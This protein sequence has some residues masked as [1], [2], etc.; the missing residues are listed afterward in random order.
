MKNK[1]L[2]SI[3]HAHFDKLVSL[4]NNAKKAVFLDKCIFWWQ[5]SKYT[6]D[7][8]KIW[9]TRK[10]PD[11]A[12]ELSI[13]ERS[14]S[15][16]LDEL[17]KSGLLERVCKL[18]ASNK[19]DK[20]QVTK[21]LYIRVTEKLLNILQIQPQD[22]TLSKEKKDS[23]CSFS[24]QFGK[25]D[26]AKLATS[27]YKDK[28]YK[29]TN[30]STVRDDRIVNNLKTPP[31][32]P[33]QV[34]KTAST[35]TY[36]IE[37]QIGERLTERLKNYIK[38]M[39]SNV[40][41]QHDV[42]Y[43]DPNKLFAEV[44]F[45]VTQEMQWSGIENPHHRVN[46]IAKLLRQKQWRTPKGFYNQWDIGNLFREQER[47]RLEKDRPDKQTDVQ[48]TSHLFSD[49]IKP[50]LQENERLKVRMA[51]EYRYSTTNP[52]E[53]NKEQQKLKQSL[54]DII[55]TIGSEESYLKQLE[56]W[57]EQK[58]SSVTR[59]LIDSVAIKIARLY[60]DRQKLMALVEGRVGLAA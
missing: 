54:Q 42:K 7:D 43:S 32:P 50:C 10:L 11:I 29:Q 55:I 1:N 9:F 47:M 5:I 20:F 44:V 23:S 13:S 17:E 45:S 49:R 2:C 22:P 12:H 41:T 3:Y 16:Y 39:L 15:R 31:N 30:N 14:V 40:Q 25:M 46:I 48:T 34:Q 57:L 56:G 38:G 60:E 21:R 52:Y 33:T 51:D 26:S 36:P 24:N 8:G 18:S 4:T 6:L 35:T 53:D 28:D 58:E 37:P 59:N 19:N 27:I